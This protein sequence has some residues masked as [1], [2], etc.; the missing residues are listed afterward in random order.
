MRVPAPVNGESGEVLSVVILFT[1]SCAV[2]ALYARVLL[3][4]TTQQQSHAHIT[5]S[6]LGGTRT[7]QSGHS[8]LVND[9]VLVCNDCVIA[10]QHQALAGS[11]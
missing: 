10:C 9:G 1:L 2:R 3:V 8:N 6:L 5:A 7:S 11:S 4:T